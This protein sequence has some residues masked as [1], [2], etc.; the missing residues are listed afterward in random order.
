MPP[1]II[2]IFACFTL[3]PG[4]SFS[5]SSG[6][7]TSQ[8]SNTTYIVLGVFGG[9]V[10][11]FIVWH[12]WYAYYNYET[13]DFVAYLITRIGILLYYIIVLSIAW[14]NKSGD[15]Y[16]H[17]HHYMIAWASSLFFV[18]DHYVSLIGLGV[19]NGIFIEGLA[20]YNFAVLAQPKQPA[21]ATGPSSSAYCLYNMNPNTALS[22]LYCPLMPSG[23]V[24]YSRPPFNVSF[25]T[26]PNDF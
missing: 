6:G 11:F 18:F 24:Y 25:N 19:A 17:L 5:F 20:A 22:V 10:F 23:T 7:G 14:S 2:F 26:M 8:M 12:I 15:V 21:S 1:S 13:W 9:I 16:V 3:L 4:F